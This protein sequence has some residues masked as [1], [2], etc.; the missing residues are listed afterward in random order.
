MDRQANLSYLDVD[1]NVALDDPL[2]TA[3]QVKAFLSLPLDVVAMA[4][5]VDPTLYRQRA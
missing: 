5:V 1:Y 3:N 2:A 4:S